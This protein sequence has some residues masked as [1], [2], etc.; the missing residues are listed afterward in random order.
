MK[1]ETN[2]P[3]PGQQLDSKRKIKLLIDLK[4]LVHHT[5]LLIK[6][7]LTYTNAPAD[8]E[9]YI[10][11]YIVDVISEIVHRIYKLLD[12]DREEKDLPAIPGS[13]ELLKSLC[14][15]HP[16]VFIVHNMILMM[17]MEDGTEEDPWEIVELIVRAD[18]ESGRRDLLLLIRYLDQD[19]QRALYEECIRRGEHVKLLRWLVEW[20]HYDG[21]E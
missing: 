15:V 1:Y 13:R 8:P 19:L 4:N 16:N 10:S 5:A 20:Q 3:P 18:R 17:W 6:D 9:G 11:L 14:E 7:R 21:D 12:P 2:A